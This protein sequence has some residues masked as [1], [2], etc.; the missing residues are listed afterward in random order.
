MPTSN[1]CLV[2]SRI[3]LLQ[4]KYA[5]QTVLDGL[6]GRACPTSDTHNYILSQIF[7]EFFCDNI[8]RH[9]AMGDGVVS[10]NAV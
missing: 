2:F 8:T 5:A 4:Q 9:G 1:E 7:N 3:K 10:A 6:I